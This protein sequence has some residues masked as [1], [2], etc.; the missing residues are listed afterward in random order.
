MRMRTVGIFIVCALISIAAGVAHGQSQ[1]AEAGK[2]IR[3]DRAWSRP[4]DASA[5]GAVY[6]TIVNDGATEDHL[7]SASTAIAEKAELHVTLTEN[8]VMK[9]RPVSSVE[10]KAHAS[11]SLVPGGTHVML[12]GLKQALQVGATFPLS[13][14]F[15]KAGSIETAVVVE[16][17]GSTGDGKTDMPGMEH[18]GDMKGMKM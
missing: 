12:I 3:I 17:S 8:G 15:E 13:L 2:S 7:L 4:A 18:G 10:V 6:F 16:K 14:T 1:L 5:N 9:M 11:T